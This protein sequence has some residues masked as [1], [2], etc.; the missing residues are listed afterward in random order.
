MGEALTAGATVL[1]RSA[2]LSDVTPLLGL[3]NGYASQ[4]IM[5]PRTELEL[6]ENIRDF[7]IAS[8][9]GAL[10]GCGALHFYGPR[11]AE[12]RSLAVHSDWKQHGVG[13][14]LMGAI[15]AEA[16][17]H[18]IQSLFAFTYVPS[19]FLKLDFVEVDRRL[20]PSKVWKDCLR[21]P[22][23]QCCDEIAMQKLLVPADAETP[24]T[25]EASN[26][27]VVLPTLAGAGRSL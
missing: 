7:T 23:L 16:A 26:G 27:L 14:R 9:G 24:L 22:K 13:K 8:A 19:F 1:I 5:L 18:G 10:V 6:A 3:I 15:E 21:C 17:A 20:L 4:G 25:E 12:V 11:T 2:L